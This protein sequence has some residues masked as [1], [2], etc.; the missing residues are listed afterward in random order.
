[1]ALEARQAEISGSVTHYCAR[2]LAQAASGSEECPGCA[3]PFTGAGSF[4]LIHGRAPSRE[5]AFLF[6]PGSGPHHRALA[7]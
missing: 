2:C 4:D 3:T 5:F 7:D 1:M 6:A